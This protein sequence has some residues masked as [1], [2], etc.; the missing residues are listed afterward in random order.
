MRRTVRQVNSKQVP[1]SVRSALVSL[2]GAVAAVTRKD[3]PALRLMVSDVTEALDGVEDV[4]IVISLA[5]LE[6]LWDGWG[7]ADPSPAD[8][9]PEN[10]GVAAREL[11]AIAGNL[12]LSTPELINSAA[13]RLEAV[14]NGD[15]MRA[16]ADIVQSKRLG[17]EPE[18]V[19]GAIALLTAIVIRHARR[20]GRSPQRFAGDICL[21]V[22]MAASEPPRAA[23]EPN[24]EHIPPRAA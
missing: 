5:S 1:S 23:M 3:W 4:L 16:A 14:R 17:S 9:N 21:A 2:Y 7:F 19:D 20:S 8:T 15:R 18:L 6:C 13:W 12:E 10:S 24:L 22:S 11:L